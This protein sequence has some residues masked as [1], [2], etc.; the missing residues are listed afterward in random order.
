[1]KA[2]PSDQERMH[3][4]E[5]GMVWYGM[6]SAVQWSKIVF[7]RVSQLGVCVW[8]GVVNGRRLCPSVLSLC[9]TL[10]LNGFL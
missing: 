6:C 3:H 1:M 2:P 4:L 7:G 5:A 10:S 8:G 9:H